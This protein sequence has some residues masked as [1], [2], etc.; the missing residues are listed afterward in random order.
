[1]S[2]SFEQRLNNELSKFRVEMLREMSDL[3]FDLLK[4][5]FLFWVGQLAATI[6]VLNVMLRDVR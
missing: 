2:A 1:M 4:W 5:T 3:R 6:A